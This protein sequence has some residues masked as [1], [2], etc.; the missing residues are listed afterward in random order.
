MLNLY[1]DPWSKK[2]Y[3]LIEISKQ[4]YKWSM[5]TEKT[6]KVPCLYFNDISLILLDSVEIKDTLN[7]LLILKQNAL[8]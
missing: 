5:K 3:A 1:F 4:K 8:T 6:Q 7:I 2:K